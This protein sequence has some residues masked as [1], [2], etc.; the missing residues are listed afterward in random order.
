MN[1]LSIPP[2]AKHVTDFSGV[3][4]SEQTELLSAKFA[5]HENAT[6][7]QVLAVLIPHRQ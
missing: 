5:E 7:E 3:L 4:S 2:L 1:P 6:T